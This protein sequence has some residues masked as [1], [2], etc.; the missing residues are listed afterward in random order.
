MLLKKLKIVMV[1]PSESGKTL[2]ANF[3]SECMNIEEASPPKPTQGVR[4]VEFE[5][6]NLNIDGKTSKI[7]IELWDCSGDHK[8]ESCWPSL[9]LGVQG[10]ILMCSPN[11]MHTASRELELLYNYF[12]SQTKLSPKQCVLFYNTADDQEDIDSLNLSSTFSKVSQVAI[13][14]KSG[15]NKLKVDFSNYVA[16]ILQV[17]NKEG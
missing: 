16:S 10:V 9:R 4:I 1:G 3:I 8:F 5:L 12:V 7:D 2:A 17:L 6:S 14:L 11:T 13:N 15:S